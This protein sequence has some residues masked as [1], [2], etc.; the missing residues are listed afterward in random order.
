MSEEKTEEKF[1]VKKTFYIGLAFFTTGISWSLY[2][3]QV[4]QQ[5]DIYFTGFLFAGLMVGFL[6]TIDN[7]IG[8][9]I[10][11]IMGSI[12]DN[13]RT[14]YGRR[15]PFIIIGVILS[16]I[17]FALIP[18]GF[19]TELYILLIWM[20]FFS[21]SMG[22]YR[23][24][25]VAL[26]PDFI[27]PLHRS[28]AN[29]VI[30]IMGGLGAIAAYTMSLA[31]DYI[32]LTL[33]FLIG[34]IIMILAL[35]VLYFKVDEN[36]AFSYKLLLQAEAEEG[37]KSKEKKEKLKLME[38]VKG[39]LKEEDKSTLFMLLTIFCLFLTHNGIEGL[40][41]IYAGSGPN[42]VLGQTPGFAGF[43]FNFVALPFIITAFPL[44]LLASKIGRRLCIKIGLSIMFV[45]LLV[46][47]LVQTLTVTIIILVLYGIGYALVNVNTIVIIWELA[48]SAKKIGTYTGLYYFFSVLAQILGPISVGSLRDL[49]GKNSLLIDGAIFLIL[50]LVFMFLVKRGE[51]ELTEEQ[52]LARQKA[53]SEL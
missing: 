42:G 46:G 49:F 41:S 4:N 17:F 43:L 3:T 29:A 26:M 25:A 13:T 32:G 48:P 34:S 28:K 16:A 7:L 20:F 5:L 35:L 11:P 10:Q 30:N 8:V 21:L 47:F 18:T 1:D 36:E 15:M 52:K 45:A 39:I 22:F 27:R 2:N 14:K 19:G 53:I 50:A 12:S 23:S 24:Q 51:I 9:I 31:S 37:E 40:F 38:S 33:T 6:M 44:S